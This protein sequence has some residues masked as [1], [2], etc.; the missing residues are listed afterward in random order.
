[1]LQILYN[2]IMNYSLLLHGFITLL[3]GNFAGVGYSKS[4]RKIIANENGWKLLHS[5]TLMGSI[6]LMTF[7]VFFNDLTSGFRYSTYLFY[8]VIISNYCFV[9]GM[10][11]AALSS[12]RGLD[13]NE[14]GRNNK[15]VYWFYYVAAILSLAYTFIFIFLLTK[16][17]G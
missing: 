3:I 13:K 4:I 12:A 7:A 6:M 10:L 11:L 8:A 5:A 1:M 9:A 2:P 15:I 14:A 17:L 16:K